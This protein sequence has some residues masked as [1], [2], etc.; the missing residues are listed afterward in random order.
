MSRIVARM[1]KM[2]AGNLGG[3]Q[4]HNQRETD[5]HSNKEIDVERSYLNYD[6]VNTESI[7]YREKIQAIITSQRTSKRA[8]RKDAVLVDEWLITSDRSFFETANTEKFFQDSVDYFAQRCGKQN[9]AYATVHLDETT[10]HMH[11]GIVPMIENRLSSKQ[12]FT[13][14]SL[15]DI[16]N[17]FPHYLQDRGHDIERGI[18]G[19]EQKHL[20]VEEYKENQQAIKDM[21]QVLQSK[22][23]ELALVNEQVADQ[24]QAFTHELTQRW[25]TE[26]LV[27]KEE[28]PSFEMTHE[29]RDPLTYEPKI[30]SVNEN[31]PK[32]YRMTFQE[33]L[34]L[35]KE[36]YTQLKDY[37]ALKW[38]KLT[39]KASELNIRSNS[40]VE[41]EELLKGK[42]EGLEA[43]IK[44]KESQNNQ[45][46]ELVDAKTS[47]IDRLADL[48]ELSMM[49]PAYVK[50]SKL[51]K[52][53]W[54]VPKD[55]WE[56]K[57]VS[58]NAVSDMLNIKDTFT[59]AETSIKRQAQ[60]GIS[61][62]ALKS[63]NMKLEREKKELKEDY[64]IL[65]NGVVKLLNGDHLS[66]TALKSVLSDKILARMGIETEQKKMDR[67]REL[68]GPSLSL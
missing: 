44:T 34:G 7:N 4:R 2:K 33:I 47:Y 23:K 31:T 64:I 41:N 13:R 5:N 50:P 28:S 32:D 53:V 18:Q 30:V 61:N 21:E 52:E 42:L 24:K 46:T 15:K 65:H 68:D 60:E 19:S 40:L 55:K 37:I 43:E 22:K 8:V 45:L 25:E 67:Q 14:Q 20:T 35:F 27:T 3:I 59:R 51:N 57:H 66:E 6:L 10:P 12:L 63:D 17:E 58:A 9:I 54:I 11:L 36:K 62:W 1:E 29:V 48:S 38:Q 49:T 16:Q 56:A 26:W 39:A